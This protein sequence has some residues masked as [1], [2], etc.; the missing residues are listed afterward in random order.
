MA[1]YP[2]ILAVIV[3]GIEG[4]VGHAAKAGFANIQA[5]RFLV[6]IGVR[7]IKH[8]SAAVATRELRLEGV[9]LAV[10]KVSKTQQEVSQ[11]G[12][13]KRCS[14][15]GRRFAVSSVSIAGGDS[16][17][18]GGVPTNITGSEFVQVCARNQPMRSGAE[19]R[20]TYGSF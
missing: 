8:Q 3:F 17:A 20:K 9:R 1:R 18:C 14:L 15:R 12:I 16:V 4:I 10:A 7:R 13:G 6:Q 11:R 2:P 19:V 5:G